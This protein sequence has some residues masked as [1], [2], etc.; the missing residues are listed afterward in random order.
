MG[1]IINSLEKIKKWHPLRKKEEDSF[2]TQIRNSD[3]NYLRDTPENIKE[4]FNSMQQSMLSPEAGRGRGGYEAQSYEPKP[5]SS[6]GSRPP[7]DNSPPMMM[8]NNPPLAREQYGRRQHGQGGFE[9]QGRIPF[10]E[11]APLSMDASLNSPEMEK[12]DTVMI[13]LRN[14]KAQNT[15]ILSE[16]RLIQDRLRRAY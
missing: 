7:V 12:L 5:P 13:E 15:Q 3:E 16:I 11:P 1:V 10:E 4:E 8:D 6:Y 2:S 9:E 14:I